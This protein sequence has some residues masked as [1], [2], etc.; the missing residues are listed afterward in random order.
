MSVGETIELGGI[1]PSQLRVAYDVE[2]DLYS[3]QASVTV[4]VQLTGG[5]GDATPQLSLAY[6]AGEGASVFGFGWALRGVAAVSVDTR[7]HLPFHDDRDSYVLPDGREI[8]PAR[9]QAGGEWRPLIEMRAGYE[10]CTYRPTAAGAPVRAER[11]LDPATRVCHWRIFDGSDRLTVLG[12]RDD[13]SSRLADPDRPERTVTW[14]ADLTVD[15]CGN[16]IAYDYLP[17][18]DDGV[19][20]RAPCEHQRSRGTQRYLKTIRWGNAEP[21]E[22]DPGSAL[23]ARWLYQLVL[24]YGDHNLDAPS[25]VPDRPWSARPDPYSRYRAGFEVRSHRLCRRLLSFHQFDELGARPVL[26]R[27]VA[28][29]HEQDLD[30]ATLQMLTVTGHRPQSLLGP[31]DRALP[32]LRF[33]YAVPEVDDAFASIEGSASSLPSGLTSPHLELVDLCGDGVPGLMRRHD[34]AW[35]YRKSDGGGSFG[36]QVALASLPSTAPAGLSLGDFDR[37]GRTDAVALQGRAAAFCERDGGDDGWTAPRGVDAI[38][39]VQASGRRL[40]WIDLDADGLTDLLIDAEDRFLWYRS[41]GK[42]GFEEPQEILKPRPDGAAAPLLAEDLRLDFFFA[43]MS[44]DGL[45]DLVSV[46]PGR[47]E[48]WPNLGRGAFGDGVLLDGDY[49]VCLYGEFDPGRVRLVDI[50]GSGRADVLYLGNGELRIWLNGGGDR[51]LPGPTVGGLPHVARADSVQ[52]LDLYHDAT[53]CLVWSS[54]LP[55]AV[56]TVHA[57][58]LT[59]GVIPRVLTTVEDGCGL[60]TSLRYGSSAQHFLRDREGPEPWATTVPV[61]TVVA[62]A[63]VNEDLLAGVTSTRRFLYHDGSWDEER[64]APRGFGRVDELDATEGAAAVAVSRVRRWYHAGEAQPSRAPWAWAGDPLAVE[65]QPARVADPDALSLADLEE[66]QR[67][68]S[69]QPLRVELWQQD[70]TAAP[71]TVEQSSHRVRCL[72]PSA[73]GFPPCFDIAEEQSLHLTHERVADDPRVEHHLVLAF[74]DHGEPVL[75]AT[76]GYPRRAAA[77]EDPA[78]GV[79]LTDVVEHT[80][81]YRSTPE[82]FDHA[83]PVAAREFAIAQLASPPAGELFAPAGLAAMLAGPLAAPLAHHQT[84]AGAGPVAMLT[85]WERTRYWNDTQTTEAPA[86]QLGTP[87]LLHHEEAACFTPQF[88]ADVLGAAAPAAAAL[89]DDGHYALADGYWWKAEPV[90]VPAGPDGFFLPARIERAD[91]ATTV[92]ERDPRYHLGPLRV[93]D[94]TGE[95]VTAEHDHRAAAVSCVTD[96]NGTVSEVAFDPLGV[97]IVHTSQGLVIDDAGAVTAYGSDLLA[98]F[99]P[100]PAATVAQLA[101]QPESILQGAA[102]VVVYDLDAFLARGEP[103]AVASARGAS[104]THGAGAGDP[105]GPPEVEISYVDGLGRPLQAKTRVEAGPAITRTGGGNVRTAAD[106]SPVLVP[107]D[108][109]WHCDGHVT[110]DTKQQP[111]ERYDPFFTPTAAYEGDTVLRQLGLA[112]LTIYDAVG[113]PIEVRLAD[114]TVTANAYGAWTTTLWDANDRVNDSSWRLEREALPATDPE[115]QAL[116]KSRAHADT[117]IVQAH[118]PLGRT[119]AEIA[120]LPGGASA[121]VRTELGLDGERQRVID[122]RGIAAHSYRTDL[123]GRVLKQASADAG[124]DHALPDALDRPWQRWDAAGNAHEQ[125]HDLLDRPVEHRVRPAGVAAVRVLSRFAYGAADAAAGSNLRGQLT[126][127]RD[128]AG[129]VRI[130]AMTPDGLVLRSERQFVADHR[131]EPDWSGTGPALDGEIHHSHSRHDA[132]GRVVRQELA[133]GSTRLSAYQPGGALAQLRLITPGRPEA[134][135]MSDCSYDAHGQR[136]VATLGNGVR[137][138]TTY[139]PHNQRIRRQQVLPAAGAVLCDIAYVHDAVGNLTDALDN[140]QEPAGGATPLLQGATITAR[141]S[142]TYDPL[143]RVTEAT[144]RVHRALVGDGPGTGGPGRGAPRAYLAD[145]G[146]LQRFTQSFAYDDA[147][148]LRQLRHHAPTAWTTAFWIS[149]T[150][151]RALPD[152]DPG[153]TPVAHPEQRFDGAGRLVALAHLPHLRWTTTGLLAGV[154]MIERAGGQPDDAEHYQYDA[155]GL[156]ARKVTEVLVNGELQLTERRYLDGCEIVRVRRAGAPY[157]ERIVAHVTAGADRLATIYRW[158]VDS[159][160]RETDD[161]HAVRTHYHVANAR[162]DAVLE[163][164]ETGGV[165]AYEEYLPYGG[166]AIMAAD[167][168]RD[169]LLRDYRYAGKERDDATGFYAFGHRYY[170]PW[171]AR[172]ISPDPEGEADSANLYQY[173]LGNPVTLGDP[174]GRQTQ[175]P[176]TFRRVAVDHAPE[177]FRGSLTPQQA[178]QVAS[179]ERVAVQNERGQLFVLTPNEYRQV[180]AE[181]RRRGVNVTQYEL[182]QRSRQL[183]PDEQASQNLE[184]ALRDMHEVLAPI[185]DQPIVPPDLSGSDGR[186]SASS[187]G[188]DHPQGGPA[189][190]N[191]GGSIGVHNADGSLQTQQPGFAHPA[192]GGGATPGTGA[193]TGSPGGNSPGAIGTPGTGNANGRGSAGTSGT[194]AP[195]AP[196]APGTGGPGSGG[197]GGTGS[198][199]G[200]GPSGGTGTAPG[201]G[202]AGIG[203]QGPGEQ[204]DHDDGQGDGQGPGGDAGGHGTEPGGHGTVA[205]ATG[206]QPGGTGADPTTS[207][208]PPAGGPGQDTTNVPGGTADGRPGGSSEHGSINGRLGGTPGATGTGTP[209]GR[210]RR[211]GGTGASHD[212]NRQPSTALDDA[213]RLAGILNFTTET[214]PNGRSGG[215]PGG[216]GSFASRIGQMLYIALTVIA[217]VMLIGDIMAAIKGAARLG[218]RGLLRGIARGG[219]AIGAFFRAGLRLAGRGMLR[220]G[221][222]LA[223]LSRV[224]RFTPLSLFQRGMRF[225]ANPTTYG[226]LRNA[227]MGRFR[228]VFGSNFWRNWDMHHWCIPR[229]AYTSGKAITNRALANWGEAGWNLLPVPRAFNRGALNNSWVFSNFRAVVAVAVGAEGYGSYRLTKWAWGSGA[230]APPP[231]RPPAQPATAR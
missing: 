88:A 219:R 59:G 176:G 189:D 200:S 34:G 67:A 164:D 95:E 167:R 208:R 66:A 87:R 227:T 80:V 203:G 108:P 107:T 199:S 12:A 84:P 230:P 89:Q 44:G 82:R 119:V 31:P 118:D 8:V 168:D 183:S 43:D 29:E 160:R 83:I 211:A 226:T 122:Q 14:L 161:V 194:P 193:G 17:E 150:S 116:E 7:R 22:R 162:G 112:T 213:T 72:Q 181:A 188:V 120:L 11:W 58:R 142:Y 79:L 177:F 110:H 224:P 48:Y 117:P 180:V 215:V 130:T 90:Q 152:H 76:V 32:P 93:R 114:G 56:E 129:V 99:A 165:I 141:R 52:I 158:T 225:F 198:G 143:Y 137:L 37:D 229:R 170:A 96:A 133:D 92:I 28:L 15:A 54:A 30:G 55:S 186:G 35:Y 98:A 144:G 159:Y 136:D 26:V 40:Q 5:R 102:N 13:V 121:V 18:N 42:Q 24:D 175:T 75:E 81:A 16:A 38:A 134:T 222:G 126:E 39:H 86:G 190:G 138:R 101:T 3:G 206:T 68:L 197:L 179:G 174:D 20:L 61:H 78:Q 69:G 191:G 71:I 6:A 228:A 205:G 178:Q 155:E 153:G 146:L 21:A 202:G 73:D 74:D 210:G 124:I 201:A 187:P 41:L 113:R 173:V 149:P 217:T 97:A 207:N 204:Q 182:G 131:G 185:L 218:M 2:V 135:L 115:K 169:V 128:G 33:T 148:N 214:D 172:W 223:G 154:V 36:Q 209:D 51:L 77:L 25:S 109:R 151:N 220:L 23:P 125:T 57:L 221:K 139:D 9:E 132:L 62:E 50:T 163:L 45:P 46:R 94:A 53:T 123:E 100:V 64:R 103:V 105:A 231:S 70:D 127:Q 140:A 65:L 27:S 196:S 147:G 111:I 184:R 19:D 4:P 171:M 91:G 212:P 166:T 192:T 216:R 49:E 106:G 1:D 145:G 60:R 157:L 10:V 195:G 85:A 156:R 63:V 104:L 47:V